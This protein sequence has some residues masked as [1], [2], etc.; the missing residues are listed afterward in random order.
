MKKRF[1]FCLLLL[2]LLGT[3]SCKKAVENKKEDLIMSAITD[4]I[5]VVEQYLEGANNITIDFANYDFK[6]NNDG[7]VVGT[8]AGNSTTGT[9]MGNATN[10]SIT[11][12]FPSAVDPLPKMNGVWKLTDSYWDYVEAEMTTA[13]GKN[14]LHL[15]K[16][17]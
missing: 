17:P 15:R 10:Y 13:S 7:S 4:G 8:K 16:K 6:F 1:T 9:W 5:W 14:I 3:F 12:N 11:S 2:L